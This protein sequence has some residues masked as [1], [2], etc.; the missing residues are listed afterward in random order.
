MTE[1][2]AAE[3]RRRVL[4]RVVFPSGDLDVVPLYVE[5]NTD[6]GAAE[7]ASEI[8]TESLGEATVVAGAAHVAS[9]AP[10]ETQSS[11]R[12]GP[13]VPAPEDADAG[14]RR[15][16]VITEGRRVSFATYFNAF[17]AS[18]WRRWTT[19]DSVTLRIRISGTATIVLYRSAAKG[20]SHPVETINVDS[21]E[22]ET[23]ERSLPLAQFVDGG[24]YWFDIVAGATGA[25]LIEADWSALV[26]PAAKG[27]ISL[28]MT[29]F[30]RR[31]FVI[32]H[33]RALGE[34]TEVL[35]LLDKFYVI[36][37]GTSRVSD[38]PDFADAGKR[39][40]DKLQVIEQPNLGG[41]GGF[42]RSMDETLRAGQSDYVLLLD[43]DIK[44]E[45]ESILRAAT[46]ADLARRPTIVGAHMFSL[47]D[48]AVLHSFGET[49]QRYLWW[50]GPAPDTTP[51][52]DFG[53]RNLRNTPW[54]HRRVD[55]DFNGW[56]M[57][58]I[59]MK[60]VKDI[61]LALPVFIK[62]DDAEY[63]LRASEA[64]YPTVSMPGVAAWHIPWVDKND[65]IDWQAYYHLRNRLVVA[66]LHSPFKRGGRLVT[67]SAELQ[68]QNLLSMRYSTA[69]LRLLAVEDVLSG[70]AHLHRD[71][72]IKPQ[73]LR[74]LRASY[75]EAQSEPDVE[76]FPPARRRAPS[77]AEA[78]RPANKKDIIVK[79]ASGSIHQLA[80]PR[81]GARER[82]Q[83]AFAAGDAHWWVLSRLDSALVSAPDGASV[84]W[85]Q[86]DRARFR[87]LG[88]RS[89]RLHLRLRREW[90]KLAAQ[91]RAAAQDFTSPE[92]W[93]HE[94][95]PPASDQ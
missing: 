82:P 13:D 7:L 1:Q 2:T 31:D 29:T 39:L 61:G 42:S 37:Q 41:S 54:L 93:R 53:R 95:G 23:V 62:W 55:V 92:R 76:S 77:D 3:L 80:K 70:P 18:Y 75:I 35:E 8:L 87:S 16:A 24:W 83:M 49:V 50:W 47:Y 88:L 33:M 81:P 86:R 4:Q 56:W 89:A 52:H 20:H 25:T 30:N 38:H 45:P 58:L 90:P 36:D 48:R 66:L 68:L 69:A 12:F 73:K 74:E 65:A 28:G 44:L 79:A 6:R 21:D 71:L 26:P 72:K 64:G 67:E 32:G 11:I 22:A 27:R 60:I 15:T 59:P 94:Y 5:T 51:R 43:D 19:I 85:H 63:G 14:A 57:C 34:A 78:G 10:G 40:G 9:A 84:S 46:F 91:Y 17:P